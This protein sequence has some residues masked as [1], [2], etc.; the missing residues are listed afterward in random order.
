MK[1]RLKEDPREWQ[2]FTLSSALALAVIGTVL[3][4]RGVLGAGAY[5]SCLAVLLLVL[6][7]CL[8]RPG[9]YRAPYRLGMRFSHFL[10]H[11]AGR[12]MLTAIFL[13]ILAPLGCVLRLCGKDLL[14]LKRAPATASYWRTSRPPGSLDQMF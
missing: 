9:W 12:V 10:G 11:Y 13:V 7:G 2:K 4:R 5:L 1:L 8:V 3:W 14:R 6:V